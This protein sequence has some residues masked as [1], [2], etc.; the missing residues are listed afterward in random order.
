MSGLLDDILNQ[1]DGKKK[2]ASTNSTSKK[3]PPTSPSPQ[4]IPDSKR[5]KLNNSNDKVGN[6]APVLNDA[7]RQEWLKN[8]LAKA[9]AEEQAR[10]R[11]TQELLERKVQEK[12][13][14]G[15]LAEVA[16]LLDINFPSLRSAVEGGVSH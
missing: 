16:V 3:R 13:D 15:T 1:I 5:P 8:E 10:E 11:E 4:D 6:A 14:E 2:D 12:Q 7:A 9:K